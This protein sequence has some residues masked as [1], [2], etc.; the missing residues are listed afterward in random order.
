MGM[1][2]WRVLPVAAAIF[3]VPPVFLGRPFFWLPERPSFWDG[4]FF[5]VP[6][7]HLSSPSGILASRTAIFESGAPSCFRRAH[8]SPGSLIGAFK[9]AIFLPGPLRIETN[10]GRGH[11]RAAVYTEA[12]AVQELP[13]GN[14]GSSAH[15]ILDTPGRRI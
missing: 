15:K 4:R 2:P 13:G 1:P 7:H 10:P 6:G 8:P 3:I 5:S 11:Q 9:A 14:P 12:E